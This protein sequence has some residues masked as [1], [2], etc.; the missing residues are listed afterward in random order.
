MNSLN[1]YN[2]EHNTI[3]KIVVTNSQQSN[4]YMLPKYG[5]YFKVYERELTSPITITVGPG[6]QFSTLNEA[7]REAM[8]YDPLN[9]ALA[10]DKPNQAGPL[11]TILLKTGFVM[12]ESLYL[13][14][15]FNYGY[16]KIKTETY[17]T[18]HRQTLKEDITNIPSIGLG[19]YRAFFYGSHDVTYPILEGDFRVDTS[20]GTSEIG[21]RYNSNHI[22]LIKM[23]YGA[24][25]SFRPGSKFEGGFHVVHMNENSVVKGQHCTYKGNS[26]TQQVIRLHSGEIDCSRSIIE[27]GTDLDP[28]IGTPAEKACLWMTEGGSFRSIGI[29]FKN[30]PKAIVSNVPIVLQG[31]TF[32]NITGNY[33]IGDAG[34]NGKGLIINASSITNKIGNAQLTD[35]GVNQFIPGKGLM[36]Q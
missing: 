19:R 23:R 4:S 7:F 2:K 6:G 29:T 1:L 15:G 33:A 32:E 31:T 25:V 9:I 36:I 35:H 28:S 10:Y 16:I 27:L 14:N 3:N 12:R 30:S 13:T 20:G 24:K 17:I 21:Y 34:E 18:C 22:Y 26:Y 5:G 11:I 8:K